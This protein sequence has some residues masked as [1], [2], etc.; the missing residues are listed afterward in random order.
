MIIGQGAE[1]ILTRQ[2]DVVVKERRTKSYR[3]PEL[4]DS[5]RKSRTRHEA[6]ILSK[7]SE[8]GIRVPTLLGSDENSMEITMSYIPGPKMR[9]HLSTDPSGLGKEIGS[10]IGKV[11]NLGIIHQDLT[12]SN[13][14]YSDGIVLIDFGLSFFSDKVEDK[15][16]DLHL[17]ERA[18][19][20]KHSAIYDDCWEAVLLGYKSSCSNAGEVFARFE[21]VQ[22]RGRNKH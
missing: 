1:A 10:L 19:A 8:A 13:M 11:H 18:L 22:Q 21:K 6:K 17:L 4:D 7:L 15:A 9:D 12:T 5:L 3:L 2:G 16:V 20:S 14:I